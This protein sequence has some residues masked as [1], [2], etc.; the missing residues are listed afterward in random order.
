VIGLGS[1]FAMHSWTARST[2]ERP[3]PGRSSSRT[4][5]GDAAAPEGTAYP[6][7]HGF[8][9][10]A[11]SESDIDFIIDVYKEACAIFA[12]RAWWIEGAT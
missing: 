5:F 11:H 4:G 12:P 1:I 2:S 7:H 9:S 10:T 8:L 3:V 6:P